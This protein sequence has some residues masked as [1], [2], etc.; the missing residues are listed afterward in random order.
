MLN[1][2]LRWRFFFSSGF[3]TCQRG[4]GKRRNIPSGETGVILRCALLRASK[5][6]SSTAPGHPSRLA[7]TDGAE[8][9]SGS[10]LRMTYA[11]L[12]R[13]DLSWRRR[14]IGE[15]GGQLRIAR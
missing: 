7:K 15:I 8:A 11:R 6:G 3:L 1:M 13:R 4:L 10:H 14:R 12:L 2:A 5:D 9:S